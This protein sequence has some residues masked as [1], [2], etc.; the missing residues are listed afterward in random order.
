MADYR[1]LVGDYCP[2]WG[3]PTHAVEPGNYLTADHVHAVGAGGDEHGDLAVLC[4]R[5]NAR[6]KDRLLRPASSPSTSRRW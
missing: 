5:C 1:A 4:N 3:V 2:G 6:K